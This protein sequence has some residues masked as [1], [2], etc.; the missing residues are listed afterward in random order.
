MER[1]NSSME[2]CAMPGFN[3][4]PNSMIS[5]EYMC[6]YVSIKVYV[7]VYGEIKQQCGEVCHAW[8]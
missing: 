2:R 6:I 1:L 5:Y 8:L 3:G 7:Y 4:K